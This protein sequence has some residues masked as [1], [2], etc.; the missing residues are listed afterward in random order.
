MREADIGVFRAPLRIVAVL[1]VERLVEHLGER[2]LVLDRPPIVGRGIDA[3]HQTAADF[4]RQERHLVGNHEL[5]LVEHAEL[6]G[7]LDR[8]HGIMAPVDVDQ[9]VRTGVGDVEQVGRVVRRT[10]RRDLVGHGG[11]ASI[12][13]HILHRL[14]HGVTVGIVRRHIRDFF[15]LAELLDQHRRDG[16][17]RGLTIEALPESIAH[18]ILAGGVVGAGD[19][20]DVEHV[21]ALRQLVEGDGDR[22]RGRAGH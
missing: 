19:P 16:G 2:I 10:E 17:R 5:H 20:R 22:A 9:K 18:A 14:G 8:Q 1:L 12:L 15:V 7:L 13:G 4:A 21:L 6:L 11:P 3:R